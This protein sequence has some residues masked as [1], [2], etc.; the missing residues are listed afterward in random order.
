M[1]I[2]VSNTNSSGSNKTAV[3]VYI[4]GDLVAEVNPTSRNPL[5]YIRAH[6][7]K[8]RKDLVKQC[9]AAGMTDAQIL[10]YV[11]V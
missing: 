4:N 3:R 10:E 9:H 8:Y 11:G 2:K 7:G 6:N 5:A 1:N